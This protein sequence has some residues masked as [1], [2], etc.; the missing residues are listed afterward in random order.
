MPVLV[1]RPIL[2]AV[3]SKVFPRREEDTSQHADRALS[4]AFMALVL[5]S[6]PSLLQNV[7]GELSVARALYRHVHIRDPSPQLPKMSTTPNSR[8]RD[9]NKRRK[10]NLILNLLH[11][12]NEWYLRSVR[13]SSR[14]ISWWRSLFSLPETAPEALSSEVPLPSLEDQLP[15]PSSFSWSISSASVSCA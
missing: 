12:S 10:A 8:M 4:Q 14:V 7:T 5:R 11:A 1:A 6:C 3:P 15:C 13:I 2:H 9:K